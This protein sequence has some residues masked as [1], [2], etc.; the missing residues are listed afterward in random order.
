MTRSL[1]RSLT[2]TIFLLIAVLVPAS[3]N[4]RSLPPGNSL[5]RLVGHSA[6]TRTAD[7]TVHL[8]DLRNDKST[9]LGPLANQLDGRSVVF[10]NGILAATAWVRETPFTSHMELFTSAPGGEKTLLTWPNSAKSCRS[11]WRPL[12]VDKRGRVTAMR[13]SFKTKKVGRFEHCVVKTRDVALMRFGTDGKKEKLYLPSAYKRWISPDD[14]YTSTPSFSLRGNRLVMHQSEPHSRVAVLNLRARKSLRFKPGK[15]V[16]SANFNG[17]NSILV[18]RLTK[19]GAIAARFS[20]T[21]HLQKEI[22]DG[23]LYGV[24]SCGKYTALS[25]KT[26]LVVRDERGHTIYRHDATHTFEEDPYIDCSGSYLYFIF[27]DFGCSTCGNQPYESNLLDLE[28]L[29][30]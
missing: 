23:P 3:A 13:L 30:D 6:L 8:V 16:T 12:G 20:T 10:Q 29:R 2:L 11:D 21:G 18:T 1:A 15:T 17:P 4:A 26:Q 9:E 27:Q 25:S 5:I 14:P 7:D 19:Q 22:Y 24:S 28:S